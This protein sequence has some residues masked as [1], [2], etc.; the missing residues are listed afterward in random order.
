MS[1]DRWQD[2]TSEAFTGLYDAFQKPFSTEGR[3]RNNEQGER[4][5]DRQQCGGKRV[6][7]TNKPLVV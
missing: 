1:W 2:G 6:Y 3:E 5:K 4:M 7:R